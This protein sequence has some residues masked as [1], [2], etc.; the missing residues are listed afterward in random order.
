MSDVD[1]MSEVSVAGGDEGVTV[2]AIFR[3]DLRMQL[4]S[5]NN[6]VRLLSKQ[7]DILMKLI[8][9][10]CESMEEYR[11]L[12]HS[13]LGDIL[14]AGWVQE[15]HVEP[16]PMVISRYHKW[17]NGHPELP[18]LE[19]DHETTMRAALSGE[20]VDSDLVGCTAASAGAM[21]GQFGQV[22]TLAQ[23]MQDPKTSGLLKGLS[24]SQLKAGHA[25][26]VSQ[27]LP[28]DG[29]VALSASQ[30]KGSIV[31]AHEIREN[32][33]F[34][35][36][37]GFE[38]VKRCCKYDDFTLSKMLAR[39]VKAM[40][41]ILQLHHN[42]IRDFAHNGQ[43]QESV[44]LSQWLSEVTSGF[45]G[46][47][48]AMIHYLRAY[49]RLYAGRGLPMMWD[50]RMAV[51]ARNETRALAGP[52]C[53]KVDVERMVSAALAS[54]GADMKREIQQL[55]ASRQTGVKKPVGGEETA[56]ARAKRVAKIK[57]FK[58]NQK[59]HMAADCPEASAGAD[60][61]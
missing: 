26:C 13:V 46:E 25:D 31:H 8:P 5:S 43:I 50:E 60:E 14:K 6:G 23:A 53:S 55:K 47:D 20:A 17:H 18:T 2:A 9:T 52:T 11:S 44:L 61:E 3:G 37:R 34:E 38:V 51:R 32:R 58:C 10:V 24:A 42:L 56:E 41:D 54:Q 16:L 40:G 48:E 7:V 1:V 28:F 19:A 27:G 4:E 21:A 29:V 35:D 12:P 36:P 39:G 15:Y 57:C 30:E 33:A 49:R 45:K 22:P 59:G